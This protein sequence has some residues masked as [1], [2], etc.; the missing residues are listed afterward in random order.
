MKRIQ[1]TALAAVSWHFDKSDG[2]ARRRAA[3]THLTIGRGEFIA[4][5]GRRV[6]QDHGAQLHCRAAAGH[7]GND[8]RSTSAI[9]LL[10][11]ESAASSWCSELRA[12][13]RT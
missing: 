7:R 3:R 11:S 4:C 6:R 2:C 13:S 8:L 9:D 12:V 5:S 1:R 10:P